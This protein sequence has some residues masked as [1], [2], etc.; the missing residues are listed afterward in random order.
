VI[1]PPDGAA[2]LT[3]GKRS[4]LVLPAA[5]VTQRAGHQALLSLE[6]KGREV[7]GQL[8]P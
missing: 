3:G 4:G 5:S 6:S 1:F 2:P 8:F 7:P